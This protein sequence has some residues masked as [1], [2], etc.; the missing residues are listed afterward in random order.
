MGQ[1]PVFLML[2]LGVKHRYPRK[3]RRLGR[4]GKIFVAFQT[5]SDTDLGFGR[6]VAGSGP[7]D[8]QNMAPAAH[9][10]ALAQSNPGGHAQCEFNFRAF[11]ERGAGEEKD[12]SRTEV[13]GKSNAFERCA[14]LMKRERQK[15]GEPLA[16]TAFNSNWR[17][18]HSGLT[19]FAE[20]PKS[21]GVTLAHGG[22]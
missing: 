19:S 15:V 12:A 22:R 11:D 21:A 9:G 1:W 13:L 8:A 3:S 16:G 17:S 18:G 10:H 5:Y 14:W 6:R 2:M 7:H 4:L 20:S